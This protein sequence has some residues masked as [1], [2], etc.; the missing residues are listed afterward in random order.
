MTRPELTH[1]LQD[2][3]AGI[4]TETGQDLVA[5]TEAKLTLPLEVDFARGGG[6]LI[7][8][9]RPATTHL[10]TGFEAPLATIRLS[11]TRQP[12]GQP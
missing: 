3:I 6:T 2:L 7:A 1:A 11:V 9:S 8:A 12:G 5:V 10:R 4:A